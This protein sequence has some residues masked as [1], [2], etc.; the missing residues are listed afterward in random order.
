[1]FMF[2]YFSWLCRKPTSRKGPGSYTCELHT[3][4]K[5][6]LCNGSLSDKDTVTQCHARD[7]DIISVDISRRNF[8]I[9]ILFLDNVVH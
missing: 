2:H 9:S 6:L 7:V 4:T 8:S 5:K 1:M 3:H